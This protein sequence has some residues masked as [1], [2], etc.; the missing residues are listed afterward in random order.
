MVVHHGAQQGAEHGRHALHH[1]GIG[2]RRRGGMR[3]HLPRPGPDPVKVR[4]AGPLPKCTFARQKSGR[5]N[6]DRERQPR[7][8]VGNEVK[9]VCLFDSRL[10]PPTCGHAHH[11]Q[12]TKWDVGLVLARKSGTRAQP[13]RPLDAPGSPMG[14]DNRPSVSSHAQACMTRCHRRCRGGYPGGISKFRPRKKMNGGWQ[15]VASP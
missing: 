10:C 2:F 1:G 15:R 11:L 12:A 5:P 14:A 6:A 4:P 8:R 9:S 3:E 13:R 7:L